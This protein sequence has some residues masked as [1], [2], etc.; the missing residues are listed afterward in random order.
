MGYAALG[1]V[2]RMRKLLD[3]AG[4]GFSVDVYDAEGWTALHHACRHAHADAAQLLL[5]YC[6]C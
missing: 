1:K 3:K 5:R 4:K 6:R 2:R